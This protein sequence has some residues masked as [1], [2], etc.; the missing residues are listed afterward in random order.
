MTVCQIQGT[1]GWYESPESAEAFG[2]LSDLGQGYVSTLF[3]SQG[4]HM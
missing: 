1:G 3:R 2:S 4:V